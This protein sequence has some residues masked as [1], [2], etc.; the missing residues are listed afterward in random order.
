MA[1]RIASR[2]A[3]ES[4]WSMKRG[5]RAGRLLLLLPALPLRLLLL[6]AAVEA[7]ALESFKDVRDTFG[8]TRAGKIL[9]RPPA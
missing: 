6:L 7:R 9:P 4:T 2:S 3:G 1:S 5:S 8:L